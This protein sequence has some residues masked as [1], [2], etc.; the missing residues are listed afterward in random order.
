MYKRAAN[1]Q[2]AN[3]H[4]DKANAYIGQVNNRFSAA[5]FQPGPKNNVFARP[6]GLNVLVREGVGSTREKVR[7]FRG[8][9]FMEG[10]D[11]I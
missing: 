11:F 10:R 3:T 5:S 1:V 9:E 7:I 8:R 4:R 6:F 2:Q